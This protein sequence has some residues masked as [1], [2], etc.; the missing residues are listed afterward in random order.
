V[1]YLDA[2]VIVPLFVDEQRSDEARTRIADQSL[3]ASS[4]SLSETS[5]AIGRLVRLRE[6]R[7]DDGK[8][9][10]RTM[11]LWASRAVVSCDVIPDDFITAT[12]YLRQF[13]LALRTPD[14]LHIAMAHRLGARLLTFDVRMAAAAAAL[15]GSLLA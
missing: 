5:S 4:L 13:E 3:I 15:G 12:L 6:V 10:L 8:I 14:A 9:A 7:P 2:S 1:I 11:D